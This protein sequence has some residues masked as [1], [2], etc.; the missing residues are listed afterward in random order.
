MDVIIEKAYNIMFTEYPDIVSVKE[1]GKMLGI[2]QKKAYSL[3]QNGAIP[4]IPCGRSYKV[5]K[6]NVIKYVLQFAQ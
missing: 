4:K 2:G 1:I 3:V 5:A 6:L